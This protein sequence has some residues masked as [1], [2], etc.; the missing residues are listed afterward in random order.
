MKLNLTMEDVL[1]KLEKNEISSEE[2]KKELRILT[3]E[4]IENA[5]LDI[6]RKYRR[7][8]PEVVFGEG[9]ETKDIV[10][11]VKILVKRNGY[12]LITR[13]N[14]YSKI[15]SQLKGLE[16]DYNKKARTLLVKKKNHSFPKNGKIGI[17][18]AGTVDIPVAEEAKVA[19]EIMGCE[20]FKSYDVGISAL[21]RVFE[22]LK[23][24]VEKNVSAI[25]VVAGMEGA[26]PSV[27]S[28]LVDVPVIG[29]PTSAG[30]GIG[31]KGV[32]ALT[33]MLQTCSPGLAVVN[34]DNGFGAGVFA[35]LIARRSKHG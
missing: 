4:R 31:E 23:K 5:A 7:G 32:G 9:K 26:L 24:M 1:K 28:S 17:L 13:V 6:H 29:V 34:I 25:V 14:N 10:K 33:T 16:L 12:A 11:I 35:G 30:Y 22:P 8:I 18:A 27:V 2:A 3:I 19:A 20:V 21:Q 15:R